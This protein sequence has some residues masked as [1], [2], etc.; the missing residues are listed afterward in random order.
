MLGF[1]KWK[2]LDIDPFDM[3]TEEDIIN[4]GVNVDTPNKAKNYINKIRR[5]KGLLTDE[6]IVKG[7]DKQRNIAKKR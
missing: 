5:R 4:Y 6:K 7:A 2:I 3:P 1:Y